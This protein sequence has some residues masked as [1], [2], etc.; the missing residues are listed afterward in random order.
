[1]KDVSSMVQAPMLLGAQTFIANRTVL[2]V[3]V[4][5]AQHETAH[6][7]SSSQFALSS[8]GADGLPWP[9]IDRELTRAR[10]VVYIGVRE[11]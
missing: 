6:R 5:V 9:A 3:C 2:I 10:I 11:R 7:G 8:C 1:M 4:S